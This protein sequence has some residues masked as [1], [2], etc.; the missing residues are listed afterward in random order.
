MRKLLGWCEQ[1]W[2]GTTL[3][4]EAVL[5]PVVVVLFVV[6]A[7]Y[8]LQELQGGLLGGHDDSCGCQFRW[9]RIDDVRT[10]LKC[11]RACGPHAGWPSRKVD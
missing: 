8:G 7:H 6:A 3:A 1:G 5:W 10:G 2:Q 4:I 11:I 9:Y